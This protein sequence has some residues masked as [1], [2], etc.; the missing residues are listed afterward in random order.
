MTILISSK[1]IPAG[2]STYCVAT[3]LTLNTY[4][5]NNIS[6][7]IEKLSVEPSDMK[8]LLSTTQ[9]IY[10]WSSLMKKMVCSKQDQVTNNPATH[11]GE[12]GPLTTTKQRMP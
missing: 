5:T 10:L 3:Y 6:C 8:D 11:A 7:F 1:V 4:R 12:Q 2:L 9:G